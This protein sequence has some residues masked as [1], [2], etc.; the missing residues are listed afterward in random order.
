MAFLSDGIAAEVVSHCT[1]LGIAFDQDVDLSRM[2][3]LRT[4]GRAQLIAKPSTAEQAAGLLAF[5]TSHGIAYKII[6][7]TSN[8]LFLDQVDY[9]VLV[10][11]TN[12]ADLS[13]DSATGKIVAEG[14]VM[15]PDLS[16]AALF[17]GLTGFEAFE[18][19]PG[20]LG[21]GLFMNAG[22]YGDELKDHLVGAQLAMPDG[23]LRFFTLAELQLTHRSS[24]LRREASGAFVCDVTFELPHGDAQ[25]IFG[26]MEVYHAK[27]H[28]YQDFMYP[29][30]GSIFSGSPY[31]VL[32]EEDRYF[33]F[34]SAVYY[35]FNYK[36]KIFRRESPINRKWLNDVI[37]K[38]FPLHYD[39][40]PFS[41]KTFNCLVNRGQGTDEMVRFIRQMEEL[42]DG[43]IVLENEIVEEF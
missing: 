9:P 36:V 37:L 2:T 23:T 28:K 20:T 29:N 6:G 42:I 18:G 21:G 31:R 39:L 10:S 5:L 30:L 14:G 15:V 26:K 11:S 24:V 17:H 25:K 43:R 13:V 16:R 41:D 38:R 35:L 8:L 34:V 4:G 19:I 1:D 7:N 22:A 40:Q 3:Y 33:K 32:G 27:R 12:M